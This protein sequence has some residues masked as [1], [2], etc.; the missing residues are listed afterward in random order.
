M[1]T[2][3]FILSLAIGYFLGSI[4]FGVVVVRVVTGNDIRTV[5]SGRTGGTNA[6]RA[7]G[8]IPGLLTAT[9]DIFKA[10]FSVWIAGWMT[11]GNPWAMALGGALAVLG[12]NYSLFLAKKVTDEN[13]KTKWQFAGGAGGAPSV[14]G[15]LALWPWSVAIVVPLGVL[16]LFGVGYA[17]LAT[18]AAGLITT[19]IFVVRA[20]YFGGP[21]EYVAY[22]GLVFLLQVWALRPNIRRLMNGTE[23]L[24]GWR[25]KRQQAKVAAESAQ[26][27]AE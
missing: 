21:W 14:G 20:M 1:Q 27:S 19:I 8:F 16:I 4:P 13:G 26:P 3:L 11:G 6:M 10:S 12:H 24:V 2:L 15:A 17:S 25:A 18:M 9:L 22:G 5:G 23:R 7:A